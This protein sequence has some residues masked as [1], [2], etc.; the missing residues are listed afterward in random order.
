MIWYRQSSGSR[1]R[2]GLL[3]YSSLGNVTES[4]VLGKT[5]RPQKGQRKLCLHLAFTQPGHCGPESFPIQ[6]WKMGAKGNLPETIDTAPHRTTPRCSTP[7]PPA[8]PRSTP[9]HVAPRASTLTTRRTTSHTSQDSA[10]PQAAYSRKHRPSRCNVLADAYCP[11]VLHRLRHYDLLRLTKMPRGPGLRLTL[12]A[13]ASASRR[14]G[15]TRP[16]DTPPTSGCG[17]R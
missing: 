4:Q 13:C 15:W 10:R 3:T 5:Q 7:P 8:A 12:H 6:D 14:T 17:P 11:E 9:R 1:K 16:R 2:Y